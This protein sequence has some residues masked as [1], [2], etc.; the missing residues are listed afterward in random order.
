MARDTD[1]CNGILICKDLHTPNNDTKHHA[2]SLRQLSFLLM[3]AGCK[4][5]RSSFLDVG[6]A[7]V[8]WRY[9]A[10]LANC[11]V[12]R[13]FSAPACQSVAAFLHRAGGSML[14]ST[15][16]HGR[17]VE[18]RVPEMRCMVEFSCTLTWLVWAEHDQTVRLGC[19]TLLLS[20]KVPGQVTTEY[21]HWCR[22][23]NRL[24]SSSLS[25]ILID[26]HK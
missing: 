23:W 20:S 6:R 9:Q 2:V 14:E 11:R 22:R 8:G 18:Q 19:S 1:S 17:G 12:W 3:S 5:S 15:A 7:M 10:G 24:A 13:Q 21:W 26:S 16:S 4:S 25:L